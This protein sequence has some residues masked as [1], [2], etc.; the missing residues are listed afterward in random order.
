MMLDR[1]R[2][3]RPFYACIGICCAFGAAAAAP[4]PDHSRAKHA[5]EPAYAALRSLQFTRAV[6]LLSDSTNAGNPEAQYLLGLM[7]L[8]GVG[9]IPDRARARTLLHTAADHDQAAAAY[10][11]ASELER[12]PAS[13]SGA[14]REWLAAIAACT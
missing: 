14:A 4:P 3:F 13:P 2:P 10:V 5:L 8:N 7:Y 6:G 9:I 11:L 1:R 12:D